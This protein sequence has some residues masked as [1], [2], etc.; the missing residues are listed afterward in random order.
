VQAAGVPLT[1]VERAIE[2]RRT[3]RRR[4]RDSF[5][6]LDEFWV[7]FDCDEHPKITEAIARASGGKIGV[8]YSNPC[9]ELWAVLHFQDHDAP[10]DRHQI[11]GRLRKLM[12]KYD[13]SKC[14]DYEL[15]RRAYADA[16]RRPDLME[17]RRREEGAPCGN[18]FTGVFKLTRLIKSNG[19]S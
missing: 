19:S 2:E 12:P 4:T 6:K 10:I 11:Q 9:F 8:A 17:R 7:V 18:P 1:I 5:E 13:K 16:D 3:Y 15:M 14:L